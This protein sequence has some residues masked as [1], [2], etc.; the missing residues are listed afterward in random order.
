MKVSIITVAYNSGATIEDT[1]ASVRAQD[2][3]DIEY[4]VID[5][6][7]TDSTA[8]IIERHRDRVDVFVSEPDRGI[9]DAMNK[10]VALATGEVVGIL[11]SDDFYEYP[12]A[13]SDVV[14]CFQTDPQADLV[15]G[16]V[17]FVRPDDL[18]RVIRHYRAGHF[19]PW[20]LRFGWMPAHPATFIKRAAYLRCGQYAL[21]LKIAADYEMFVRLLHVKKAKFK[22]IDRVLVRMRAGGVSTQG[23][24][25]SL[26]LNTEIVRACRRNG[27]YTNLALVL[28]KI[29]FK[30]LELRAGRHDR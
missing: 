24:R 9:Y 29:P 4:I 19:R 15:S 8:E 11:N 28:S 18:T 3:G 22:R 26:R 16:D 27:L 1:I 17:V 23:I 6:G 25:S 20:M 5:G 14:R 2:Y 10:G 13:V 30:L 12:S 7:S 21:D